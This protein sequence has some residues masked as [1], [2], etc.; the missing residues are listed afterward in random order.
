MIRQPKGV[1]A[2]GVL[3]KVARSCYIS[4]KLHDLMEMMTP[5]SVLELSLQKYGVQQCRPSQGRE[6]VSAGLVTLFTSTSKVLGGKVTVRRQSPVII[7]EANS[8]ASPQCGPRVPSILSTRRQPASWI[9]KGSTGGGPAI[10][11]FEHMVCILLLFTGCDC[12]AGLFF[13]LLLS[14]S[15]LL[16]STVPTREFLDQTGR[17]GLFRKSNPA[18]EESSW[19]SCFK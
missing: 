16:T 17:R 11:K 18:P 6:A 2:S 12:E 8:V 1:D 15:K 5:Y 7:I 4:Q 13:L 19:G 10:P 3:G 14:S 9:D